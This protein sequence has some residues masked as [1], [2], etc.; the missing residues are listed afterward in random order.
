MYTPPFIACI[1]SFASLPLARAVVFFKFS[2][3]A[4]YP[5]PAGRLCELIESLELRSYPREEDV[6]CGSPRHRQD[7]KQNEVMFMSIP[8]SLQI[9]IQ[10][11]GEVAGMT[12]TY[13]HDV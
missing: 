10:D 12:M 5:S 3:A 11:R 8:M 2:A 1:S 7:M 9:Q 6:D 13:D 4:E